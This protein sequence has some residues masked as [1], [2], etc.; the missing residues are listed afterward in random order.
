MVHPRRAATDVPPSGGAADRESL[1]DRGPDNVFAGDDGPPAA[2]GEIDGQ[3]S[4]EAP[5]DPPLLQD[6]RLK[7]APVEPPPPHVPDAIRAL[8]G[9]GHLLPG[10]DANAYEDLRCRSRRRVSPPTSSSGS[11]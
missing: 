11:T 4:L 9:E 5:H 1:H 8:L 3:L 10:E 2:S 6:E 7:R